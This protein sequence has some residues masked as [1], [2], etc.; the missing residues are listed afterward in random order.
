V[1][2]LLWAVLSAASFLHRPAFLFAWDSFGYHLYLPAFVIHDDPLVHDMAWVEEARNRYNTWGTLYQISD[3]PDGTHTPKYTMGLAV[4]WAPWFLIGHAFA[5]IS[6]APTDGYSAPYQSAVQAG[7]LLYL[8]CG[9]LALRKVLRGF[10]SETTTSITLTLLL[11]ATN[12]VDHV[13]SGTTMPHLTL[14]CLYAF[15]VLLTREWSLD[16]RPRKALALAVPL[17]LAILIRPSEAVCLLIPF[18]WGAAGEPANPFIRLWRSRGQWSIVIVALFAIGLPQFLYWHAATGHWLVD[19]YVNAGEG[20]DL[21]GPHTR[22]FLFSFRK[23][24]YVYTPLML[25][26]TAGIFL[27]RRHAKDAFLPVLCFFLANLYLLSSWTCWWYAE[28]FGSRAM[29]GSYAVMAL[30]LAAVVESARA[31][32]PAFRTMALTLLSGLTVLNLFQ[33]WQYKHL[34]I[35]PSRMTR[36]AYFAVLGRTQ[37]PPDFNDLLLVDRWLVGTDPGPD[38]ARYSSRRLPEELLAVPPSSYD[39]LITDT[40]GSLARHAY[41][42]AGKDQFT[43]AVRVPFHRLTPHDHA[44]VEMVWRVKVAGRPFNGGFINTM[45]H[46]GTN[47]A[48]AGKDLEPF[49]PV[50]GEWTTIRIRYLTPEV[51]SVED[52]FVTYFWSRD[53]LPIL[54]EGP[55]ITVHELSVRPD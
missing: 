35:H 8:L 20:F 30:P 50:P 19:T 11:I 7:V 38:P 46:A 14:F 51:R 37:R 18:L 15:I 41:A 45:E 36:T 4:L 9:L 10:F 33:Y 13:I 40:T 6:G 49:G 55:F 43:P 3:L 22:K 42:L 31:M 52:P 17:G 23:G 21:L 29:I 27:L 24:W 39:T 54:V 32:R 12:L 25:L 16:R 53:T 1:V 2:I 5:L 26:A 28:S 47:Y 44:W 48:Y 34:I